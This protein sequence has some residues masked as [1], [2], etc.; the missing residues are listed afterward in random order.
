MG[1]AGEIDDEIIFQD[2]D[3]LVGDFRFGMKGYVGGNRHCSARNLQHALVQR[4]FLLGSREHTD[5]GEIDMRSRVEN[6]IADDPV[7]GNGKIEPSEFGFVGVAAVAGFLEDFFYF[8]R[9]L[10]IGGD[11][12]IWERLADELNREEKNDDDDDG[13]NQESKS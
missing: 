5:F 10:E 2:G 1:G 3:V 8:G 6:M 9:G 13:T 12:W 11:W 4:S 7:G